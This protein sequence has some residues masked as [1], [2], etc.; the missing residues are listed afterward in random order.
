MK[1]TGPVDDLKRGQERPEFAFSVLPLHEAAERAAR[2]IVEAGGKIL[3]SGD[4][5][6]YPHRIDWRMPVDIT[7]PRTGSK[8]R[9]TVKV[10]VTAELG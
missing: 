5:V 1:I 2:A 6:I 10:R 7:H 3:P 9:K 4:R 8:I